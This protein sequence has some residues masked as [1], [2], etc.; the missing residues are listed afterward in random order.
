MVLEKEAEK[1]SICI[2]GYY[3]VYFGKEYYRIPFISKV[4]I[5]RIALHTNPFRLKKK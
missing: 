3:F 1:Q 5:N 4:G 2:I